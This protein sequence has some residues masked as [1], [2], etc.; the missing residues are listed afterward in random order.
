M[1][2][3]CSWHGGIIGEKEGEGVTHTICRSCAEKE[4]AEF[5]RRMNLRTMMAMPKKEERYAHA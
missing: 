4:K 3:F 5:L 2:I 1:L